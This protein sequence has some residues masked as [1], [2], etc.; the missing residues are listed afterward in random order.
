MFNAYGVVILSFVIVRISAG[1]DTVQCQDYGQYLLDCCK[2]EFPSNTYPIPDD[3]PECRHMNLSM[4]EKDMCEAKK[5]GFVTDDGKLDTV[6][7]VHVMFKKVEE[8]P[9]LMEDVTSKCIN[10]DFRIYAIDRECDSIKFVR[11]VSMQWVKRCTDWD[12]SSKCQQFND[13]VQECVNFFP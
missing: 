6:K 1:F 13:L 9:S 11:C 5:M 10:G 12:D 3:I 8:D 2:N 4:C 7:V